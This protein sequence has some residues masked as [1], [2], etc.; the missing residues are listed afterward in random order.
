MNAYTVDDYRAAAKRA[1]AAGN[2]RAAE[3]LA[4][5]GMALKT[6]PMSLAPQPQQN[7]AVPA[8]EKGDISMGTA[9]DIATGQAESAATG[10]LAT[11]QRL[12]SEGAFGKAQKY[13][14]ENYGNPVREFVGLP[15]VDVDAVN[16]AEAERLQTLS[17]T[18]AEY[19]D[20]KAEETG[21]YN[22]TTGDINSLS[23]FVNFVGQKGA[24][25][26]AYMAPA[27]ATGSVPISMGLNYAFGTGEISSNLKEIEGKTQEEKDQIAASGGAIVA[28]VLNLVSFY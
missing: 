10:G 16:K 7:P 19:A 26:G 9:F 21:F 3:E 24:Q 6:K 5:A 4:Q 12:L 27:L 23:D 15:P 14:T 17:D 8:S 20:Q 28:S 1:M 2:V 25:A 11:A 18:A 13:L 22:M